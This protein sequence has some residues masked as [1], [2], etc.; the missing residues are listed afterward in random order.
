MANDEAEL[1]RTP[2]YEEHRTLG[3][4]MVAFGGWEMPVQYSGINDEHYAVRNEVGVFDV[5]HMGQ[6]EVEGDDAFL[7][8]QMLLPGDVADLGVGQVMYSVMCNEQ[9]GVIDDLEI[10]RLGEKKYLL[11]VNAGRIPHDVAWVRAR[12]QP[13]SAL[14]ILDVSAQTAMLAV[15]GPR[16]EEVVATLTGDLAYDLGYFHCAQIEID[17][18]QLLISRTGYTGEDGFEIICPR[19]NIGTIWDQTLREGAKACG[20]G[21]RD[22]LRTEMGFSL[23]GHEL[24]EESN[25]FEA[26]LSWVLKLDKEENFVGKEAL[27]LLKEEGKYLRR[28]GFKMIEK[29]IPRSEYT[30]CDE[31][32]NEIGVVTSGTH[33]PTLGIGIGMGRVKPGARKKGTSLLIDM[34]GKLRRAEVVS[35]PFVPS[36]VKR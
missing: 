9:G 16:A 30:I 19:D 36:R 2:L 5:S 28:V 18:K 11:V 25:P 14:E 34:R 7:F 12:A 15:Q 6:I 4:R 17:G 1:Q 23:Y 13:F 32:G 8:L 24:D 33:S 21:A 29:G 27:C 20:L 3:G 31:A 22:T 26:G 35:L 10:C